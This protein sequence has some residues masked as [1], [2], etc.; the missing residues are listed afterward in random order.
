MDIRT[1]PNTGRKDLKSIRIKLHDRDIKIL[2]RIQ[3]ALHCGRILAVKN[4]PYSY[5][6]VSTKR[7]MTLILHHLNGLIRIKAPAMQ[8]ACE[9][10]GILF[11]EANYN[12]PLYDPYFSGLIDTD[13]SIVFNYAGN[14]IE[15][16]LEFKYTPYTAKLN[17]DK[18][19][20]LSK[21]YHIIRGKSSLKGGPKAFTSIA[22]K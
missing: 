18:T 8:I 15:C 16:N 5:Y 13:G 11:K 20:P 3:N 17:F 1:N 4:Q 10:C 2:K 12:I 9:F 22:W 6:T 14:R 7:D 19:I 21:P